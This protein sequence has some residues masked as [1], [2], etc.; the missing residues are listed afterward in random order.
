MN[1][2]EIKEKAKEIAKEQ[3]KNFWGSLL[4]I[5]A[6]SFLCSLAVELLVNENSILYSVLTLVISFFTMT[7][8]VGFYSY[9]LKMVR[10][11]EKSRED[12]FK[13]VGAV[14]PLATIAILVIIFSFLWSLL[15]IIPGIIAALGYSMVYLIYVDKPD[16]LPME[17]LSQSKEMMNGY[18]W[19]YFVFSLSFLG[20]ILFSVVTLGIGL[21]WTIP[22]MSIAEIIYYEELRK[23][24][25]IETEE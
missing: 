14:L 21:I 23:K 3:L 1:R 24:K 4:I 9:L 17:Y 6:I 22:Y 7:L 16:K 5:I 18:K 2:L 19:D 13:Y 15:F 8:Q 12:L 25:E 10:N 11:E 20:W